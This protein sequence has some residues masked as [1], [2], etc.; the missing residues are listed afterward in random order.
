MRY[1]DLHLAVAVDRRENSDKFR[2][3]LET[4]VRSLS[5]TGPRKRKRD[6]DVEFEPIKIWTERDVRMMAQE[7]SFLG[8]D[9]SQNGKTDNV[10]RF[11]CL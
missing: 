2:K 10:A 4:Y 5:A 8:R 7:Q 1:N 6:L 9:N 11:G 3:R